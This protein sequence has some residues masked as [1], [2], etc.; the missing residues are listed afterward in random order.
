[1]AF[2]F[3]DTGQSHRSGPG[4]STGD[5]AEDVADWLMATKATPAH[6]V[7]QS[8]GGLVAQELALGHPQL[9][10][11]LALVSTHAGGNAW[12]KAVIASWVFLKRSATTGEFT[13]AVLPWLVAPAFYRQASQ[14]EGLIQF[15]DRN[16][17]PQDAE[18]FA[19]QAAAAIN[20]DTK[21]RLAMIQVPT[22]VLVGELDLLNP[23]RVAGELAEQIPGANFRSFPAW[24]TCRT[25]RINMRSGSRSSG[26]WS[27]SMRNVFADA[28]RFR[29]HP[30]RK[31]R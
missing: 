15:A 13:R 5:M 4:Y 19:R 3:R 30:R 7:G 28:D 11:S 24:P 1:M 16:S 31:S 14:V 20:H 10:K 25:S 23:P 9:V 17:W 8:L 27:T 21:D 12:R 6:I 22:L 29:R 18:A 26:S 2:D